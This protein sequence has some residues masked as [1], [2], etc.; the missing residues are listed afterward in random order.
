MYLL[1]FRYD[2]ANRAE[3]NATEKTVSPGPVVQ[4]VGAS[5]YTPKML[6]VQFLVRTHACVAGSLSSQVRVGSNR[7]V[8]LSHMNVSISLH[9]S[10][11]PLP[12]SLKSIN[13]STAPWLV[14]LSGLSAG[15][16]TKGLPV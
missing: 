15:L 1:L 7:S 16:Q 5:S 3:D 14:W 2:E 12:H 13:I 6:Q 10:L 9:L 4:L 8:F 11:S